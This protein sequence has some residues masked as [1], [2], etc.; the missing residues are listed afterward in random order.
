[1]E[2]GKPKGIFNKKWILIIL[3]LIIIIA[4]VVFLLTPKIDTDI[5]CSGVDYSNPNGTGEIHIFLRYTD[6]SNDTP[7]RI[8]IENK[9]IL[10]NLTDEQNVTREYNLTTDGWGEGYIENLKNGTYKV[11]AIFPGDNKYKQ[12]IEN[13]EVTIKYFEPL[14]VTTNN[15][16]Y[17]KYNYTT[18]PKYQTRYVVRYVYV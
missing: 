2:D 15:T 11:S 17:Y 3:A 10:V 13:D 14:H 16:T 9:T 7:K 12:S 5:E 1:M 4:G 8:E 6:H 18:Q